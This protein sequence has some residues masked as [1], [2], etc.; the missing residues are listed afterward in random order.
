MELKQK[1]SISFDGRFDSD[2]VGIFLQKWFWNPKNPGE[3]A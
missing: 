3:L 2:G 1:K